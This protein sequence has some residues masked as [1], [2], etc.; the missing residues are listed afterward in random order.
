MRVFSYIVRFDVGFAP[1]PFH[2]VCSLATCKQDIRRVAQVGDW[3]VGTGSRPKGKAGNLVYAMRVSEI[4]TFQEYWDDERFIQK[5]PNLRGSRM[6][7]FGDNIY[8][9]GPA[10]EWVQENSRHSKNDGTVEERHLQ[11][12]TKSDRVLL[13]DE[14]VYF[15][16]DG[17]VIPES[18]RSGYD[19]DLVHTT[20]AF[21]N[22]FAD[23]QVTAVVE[24]I[25]SL[26]PGVQGRP[27]DWPRRRTSVPASVAASD[28]A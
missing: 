18:L 26:E 21:R 7:H 15:G 19:L 9:R 27:E 3:I 12:D 14:F 16:G 1:N 5:R 4:V 11:R 2:G 28:A 8:H 22:K 20:P 23:E 10:N 24:W 6:Q 25:R 17:P 13:A